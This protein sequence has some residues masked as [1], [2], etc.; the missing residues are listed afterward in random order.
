MNNIFSVLIINCFSFIRFKGLKKLVEF[1]L[2][3]RM[4][5]YRVKN[6]KIS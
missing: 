5:D 3:I 2:H 6:T 1:Y 4:N